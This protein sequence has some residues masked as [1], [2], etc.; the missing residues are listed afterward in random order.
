MALIKLL[1]NG[2]I[3][4]MGIFKIVGTIRAGH[5]VLGESNQGTKMHGLLMDL[6]Q[7]RGKAKGTDIKSLK[8]AGGFTAKA[9]WLHGGHNVMHYS[10]GDKNKAAKDYSVSLFFYKE[11]DDT[12]GGVWVVIA[13]GHH[14]ENSPDYKIVWGIRAGDYGTV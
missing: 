13:A 1:N 10:T 2:Q 7:N 9:T 6:A 3:E 8:P 14:T 5:A 12:A 11:S 4:N